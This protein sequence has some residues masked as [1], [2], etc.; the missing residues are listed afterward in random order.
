MRIALFIERFEPGRG[1]VENV[2]WTVAHDLARAGDE[3]LVV[4]RRASAESQV[5]VHQVDVSERWQ[6]LRVSRFSRA[7]ARIAPRGSFDVVYSLAR[8]AHQDVYRAGAGSHANYMERR[9]RKVSGS[10]YKL[11][12]R[13]AM[14][15]GIE[16]RVF[17]DSSQTVQCGSEM[18]RREL[19]QRYAIPSERLVVV[20]NGVDLARFR[21]TPERREAHRARLRSEF[22]AG[23]QLVWLFAGSGFARKGLDTALRAL[24]RAECGDS[25]LWIV[26]ADR[27]SAWER[28][29]RSLGVAERVHF[30][31]FRADMPELYAAADALVLPTRYDACANVC[32]EA[33]AAGIPIVTTASNGAAESLEGGGFTI[34]DPEDSV[35][36]AAALDTLSDPGSRARMGEAAQSAAA[37]LG[38]S[39]HIARLR[40]LFARLAA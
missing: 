12:P 11:S 34:E 19:Q 27:A 4:A 16:R 14:L 31:G 15:L 1:G 40:T 29:A 32:F 24:A 18:V 21:Q 38:W 7:T 23:N 6:P 22:G 2:A 33:A 30:L 17:R 35:A 39:D 36:V 25:Q 9:Y 20:R 3:V 13:H 10:L 37:Q 5:R 8:T 28:L 26:G